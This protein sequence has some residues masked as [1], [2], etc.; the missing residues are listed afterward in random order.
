MVWKLILHSN[1]QENIEIQHSLLRL[2]KNSTVSSRSIYCLFCD[3]AIIAKENDINNYSTN[4][5][6]D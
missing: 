5:K 1:L 4:K 6:H 3:E 2:L